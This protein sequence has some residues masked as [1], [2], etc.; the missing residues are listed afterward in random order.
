M[1]LG[2]KGARK[3]AYTLSLQIAEHRRGI[4]DTDKM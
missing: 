2:Q 1:P 4:K 3:I